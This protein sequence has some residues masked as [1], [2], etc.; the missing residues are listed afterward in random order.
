M[1]S[2]AVCQEWGKWRAENLLQCHGNLL[3]EAWQQATLLSW[4]AQHFLSNLG[5]CLAF[6]LKV[7]WQL[8]CPPNRAGSAELSTSPDDGQTMWAPEE[9]SSLGVS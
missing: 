6:S 3:T 7:P 9:G 1:V 5:L 2:S 4:V 8:P